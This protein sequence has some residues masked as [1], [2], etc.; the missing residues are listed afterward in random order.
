M[1]ALV[2]ALNVVLAIALVAVVVGLLSWSILTQARGRSAAKDR[3]YV[4]LVEPPRFD[5]RE[6]TERKAA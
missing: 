1:N 2:I 3:R 6:L 4:R 5:T